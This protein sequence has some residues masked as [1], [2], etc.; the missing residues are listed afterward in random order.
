MTSTER[1]IVEV[2]GATLEIFLQAGDTRAPIVCA[3]HPASVFGADTAGLIAEIALASAVCVNPRGLGGSSPAAGTALERMVEDIEAARRQ[4]DIHRWVFWGMSGGGWLAQIYAHLYP[5]ALAGIVVESAC[6]CF[7]ERLGDPACALSPF[8]AAWRDALK[9]SGLLEA[10]SHASA[11]STDD[12][13]WI[14]V[15]GVG[16]VLRRR[17]GPAL[18]VSPMPIDEDMK[19]AMPKLWTFD[20]RGWLR[21]V[22]TPTLVIAGSA[23]P[24]VPVDRVREVHQGIPGSTF[25]VVEGGG[26]VP[27]STKQEAA[28]RAV[29]AFAG[30]PR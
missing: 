28:V 27:S 22:R 21:D 5:D 4:L 14:E 25:V 1:R 9:K 19:R 6:A 24:I 13:E 26:H 18:L 23:D 15:Y 29:R 10:G 17:G 7:R 11:S 12:A 2:D 3:A 30:S 16:Q 8:F 20:S